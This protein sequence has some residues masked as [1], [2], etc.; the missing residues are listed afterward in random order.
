MSLTGHGQKPFG[1]AM[2]MSD[3]DREERLLGIAFSEPST[4]TGSQWSS[5][6]PRRGCTYALPASRRRRSLPLRGQT[7]NYR[8][9]GMRLPGVVLVKVGLVHLE[10]GT[11]QGL[12]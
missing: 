7:F 6:T 5:S 2:P 11:V 9:R 4:W 10:A 8:Y 1:P 3:G 12:G